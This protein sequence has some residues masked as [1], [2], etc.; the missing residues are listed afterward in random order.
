M[1]NRRKI[2]F[3][4]KYIPNKIQKKGDKYRKARGEAPKTK[5][6]N[7]REKIYKSV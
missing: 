6:D 1:E 2:E 4:K 3:Q 7:S 5:Y